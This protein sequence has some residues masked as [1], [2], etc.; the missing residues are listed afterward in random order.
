[1]VRCDQRL[2]ILCSAWRR[3]DSHVHGQWPLV[4]T[5]KLRMEAVKNGDGL[6]RKHGGGL[7]T[8]MDLRLIK[9]AVE[10]ELK[11]LV[12][13]HAQNLGVRATTV[14]RAVK[15]FGRKSSVRVEGPFLTEKV[16]L[17][18]DLH[19]QGLLNSLKYARTDHESSSGRRPGRS[20][21]SGSAKRTGASS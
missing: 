3:R 5:V 13:L 14:R 11:K 2:E 17:H 7:I 10:N 8:E 16:Q 19:G 20:T 9:E 18:P 12:Q 15:M 21:Q 6:E 4:Y 1:M